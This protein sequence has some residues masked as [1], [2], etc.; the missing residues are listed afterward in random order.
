MKQQKRWIGGLSWHQ[1]SKIPICMP[2]L[3]FPWLFHTNDFNLIQE[4]SQTYFQLVPNKIDKTIKYF[5]RWNVTKSYTI[6]NGQ[7]YIYIKWWIKCIG[8]HCYGVPSICNFC[9]DFDECP[10]SKNHKP[11]LHYSCKLDPYKPSNYLHYH[12]EIFKRT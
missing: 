11:V 12:S 9:F 1:K 5:H 4:N 2:F 3:E 6:G 8:Q 10:N 7:T